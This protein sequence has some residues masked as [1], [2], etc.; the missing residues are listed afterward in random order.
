MP[1]P[2]D[3]LLQARIDAFVTE[4]SA[5]VRESAVEAVLGALGGGGASA[6]K[7]RKKK[8]GRRKATT[9]AKRAAPKK[10]K[11]AR[12]VRRTAADLEKIGARFLAHVKSHPGKRLD[13]IA[14]T[15]RLD[16]AVLKR[17]VQLLM[18]AKKVRTEGQR[19]GTTYFAGRGTVNARKVTN[20]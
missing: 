10:T 11:P 18:E 12:R 20:G 8:A 2:T 17:P 9:K 14:K 16:T 15:L 5:I 6:P 1:T 4:I 3:A 19:R 7:R 13:Q